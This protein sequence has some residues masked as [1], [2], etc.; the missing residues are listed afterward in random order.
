MKF[1]F[2]FVDTLISQIAAFYAHMLHTLQKPIG[3]TIGSD[4][5]LITRNGAINWAVRN[6]YFTPLEYF[7][8]GAE[9]SKKIVMPTNAFGLFS[10]GSRQRNSYA[11]KPET[12]EHLKNIWKSA[13]MMVRLNDVLWDQP[14]QWSLSNRNSCTSQQNKLNLANCEIVFVWLHF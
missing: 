11:D 4:G 10:V 12:T 7:V 8:W 3:Q 6:C 1:F 5:P 14:W 13:W 2:I 9:P